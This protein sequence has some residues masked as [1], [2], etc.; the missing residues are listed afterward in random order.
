MRTRKVIYILLG[1]FVVCLI[2]FIGFIIPSKHSQKTLI[3]E[4]S[5]GDI[6]ILLFEEQ[7]PVTTSNFKQY[8]EKNFYDGLVFHRVIKDFMIQGG[9]FDAQGVQKQTLPAISLEHTLAT[10]LSNLEGTLAM[11]RT[12]NPDSATAQFFINTQDNFFLDYKNSNE[13]GYAVFGK[14]I[15][16]MDIVKQIESQDT[17]RKFNFYDDW[18]IDDVFIKRV[19]YK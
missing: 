3:I 13:P 1:V 6:E 11:A 19:Y 18:P 12:N 10:G 8:V 15:N 14:V 17:T 7:A 5:L 4:T 2:I 16:G 9:G